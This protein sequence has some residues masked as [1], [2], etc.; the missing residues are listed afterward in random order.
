[1]P[2]PGLTFC[3][4]DG[5]DVTAELMG[6]LPAHLRAAVACVDVFHASKGGA[7]AMATQMGV[8][9]LGCV[10]LDPQISRAAEQGRSIQ[11]LNQAPSLPAFN[12]IVD[13]ALRLRLPPPASL[14]R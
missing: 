9:F 1:V 14:C 10:P 2:L 6:H 13:S 11:D 8:P 12:L 4:S 3:A 7:K 5:A